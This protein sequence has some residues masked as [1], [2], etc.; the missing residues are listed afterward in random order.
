MIVSF[1]DVEKKKKLSKLVDSLIDC[2]NHL[3]KISAK[4]NLKQ[5]V[6]RFFN[7][8]TFGTFEQMRIEMELRYKAQ[9]VSLTT[10]DKTKL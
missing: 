9:P 10:A 7:E 1:T 4:T 2:E 6:H 3:S 8:K 5:T